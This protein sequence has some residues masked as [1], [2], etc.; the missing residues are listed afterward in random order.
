MSRTPLS[1]SP[2]RPPGT[3][4]RLLG[5][6]SALQICASQS[7]LVS[8][9][10]FLDRIRCTVVG[11]LRYLV[12]LL[13]HSYSLSTLGC[14]FYPMRGGTLLQTGCTPAVGCILRHFSL[15]TCVFVVVGSTALL[16]VYLCWLVV[17]MSRC[18]LAW[19]IGLCSVVA[20]S[21]NLLHPCCF[22]F[23]SSADSA[24][25]V[26]STTL[27]AV[28]CTVRSR[29]SRSSPCLVPPSHCLLRFRRWFQFR[30]LCTGATPLLRLRLVWWCWPSSP[31]TATRT[32]PNSHSPSALPYPSTAA[33]CSSTFL[34]HLAACPPCGR[35]L[36]PSLCGSILQVARWMCFPL[37]YRYCS[38]LRSGC[39]PCCSRILAMHGQSHRTPV[40]VSNISLAGRS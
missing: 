39:T 32:L 36:P 19:S 23:G 35:T 7:V 6:C 29:Y 34:S 14:V 13:S 8:P 22:F 4:S 31:T 38:V 18:F 40:A 30:S 2:T 15:Q 27:V 12:V 5:V 16:S 9:R 28:V 11:T 26:Y 3:V 10:L 24:T 37:H 17:P 20:D 1:L 21:H 33:A 25:A